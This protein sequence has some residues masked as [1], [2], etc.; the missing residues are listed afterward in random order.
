[1]IEKRMRLRK[2]P[3]VKPGEAYLLKETMKEL[4]VKSGEEIE[5]VVSKKRFR[6]IAKESGE[7]N[8]RE[9]WLSEEEMHKKG[10]QDETISSVRKALKR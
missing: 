3:N 7:P 4:G 2:K 10:L 6:F 8:G 5:I 1:M 9:V